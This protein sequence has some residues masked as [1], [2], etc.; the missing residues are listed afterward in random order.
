MLSAV[1]PDRNSLLA[2]PEGLQSHCACLMTGVAEPCSDSG[3]GQ[4]R[5]LGCRFWLP[6]RTWA[7]GAQ[8]CTRCQAL[9]RAE[10]PPACR[11]PAVP[12]ADLPCPPGPQIV[13]SVYGPDVFGNDVVR[14]YGAVHVPFSPGR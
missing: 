6:H 10:H 8:V 4:A 3:V 2:A 11:S 12:V 9:P 7:A 13:L 1:S 14:G 5:G